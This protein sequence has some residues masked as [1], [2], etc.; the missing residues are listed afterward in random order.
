[1]IS[2]TVEISEVEYEA[3]RREAA[4]AYLRADDDSIRMRVRHIIVEH[5]ASQPNGTVNLDNIVVGILDQQARKPEKKSPDKIEFSNSATDKELR[6]ISKSLGKPNLLALP[7]REFGGRPTAGWKILC[8]IV[9]AD[10]QD[11][12]WHK[13]S[14]MDA[15][16]G[17]KLNE[18][19]AGSAV[20]RLVLAGWLVMNS[21]VKHP[22]KTGVKGV[23]LYTTPL[24]A[25]SWLLSNQNKL[26]GLGV[27]GTVHAPRDEHFEAIV[28]KE[29]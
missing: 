26:A 28:K 10:F 8:W 3:L 7:A 29:D 6:K 17:C 18:K 14:I 11:G 13:F 16:I 2:V 12:C 23:K 4:Y 25:R 19:T 15:A 1:M 24:S 5:L 20:S 27:S 22:S 9:Q 21:V